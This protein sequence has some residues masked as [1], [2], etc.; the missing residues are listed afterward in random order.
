MQFAFLKAPCDC[1][2]ENGLG[3]EQDQ[4]WED[5]FWGWEEASRLHQGSFCDGISKW[6]LWRYLLMLELTGCG[7]DLVV[8]VGHV[9]G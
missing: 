4:E 7:A 9:D 5:H 3:W 2:L 8:G 6:S 1:Y